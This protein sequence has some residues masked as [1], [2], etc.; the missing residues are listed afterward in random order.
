MPTSTSFNCSV[1]R[2]SFEPNH[3]RLAL[4]WLFSSSPGA[5]LTY[6]FE[7]SSIHA[8]DSPLVFDSDKFDMAA[9]AGDKAHGL[10]A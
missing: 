1:C 8:L 4:M 9:N 2:C 3:F 7:S 6:S 10:S 5:S